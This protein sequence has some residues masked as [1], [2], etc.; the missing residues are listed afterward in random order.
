M[1]NEGRDMKTGLKLHMDEGEINRDY[2]AAKDKR[3]QVCILADRNCCSNREMAQWLLDHGCEVDK[4]YLLPGPKARG[5]QAE[6][7]E[8][9]IL[10]RD[11]VISRS[12]ERA[13]DRDQ[14]VKA[15]A[16]KPRLSLVPVQ[17]IYDIARVREYGNAKYPEGGVDNWKQVDPSR[18]WDAAFRHFLEC[19]RDPQSVDPESGLLH[20][21]HLECNLAFIAELEGRHV[22][23]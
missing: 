2:N 3:E 17:I 7:M 9:K 19:I 5:K 21:E 22:E 18:Y 6:K 23:S 16:G 1:E 13:A 20:R 15:D 11:E 10:Y 4:R 14:T 12:A 8:E